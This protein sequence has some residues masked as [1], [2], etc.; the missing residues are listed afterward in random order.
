M[1]DTFEIRVNGERFTLWETSSVTRSIEANCGSFR[2]SSTQTV[3][4]NYPVREGDFIQI[5]INDD[6]KITG[7][8]DL[9]EASGTKDQGQGVTVSGRDNIQD[10]IDSSMPDAVKEMT[11]PISLVTLCQNV[12]DA[13]GANIPVADFSAPPPQASAL[14]DFNESTD[15]TSDSG[16]KCMDFLV[17][18]A[19]KKQVY[20]VP[21][22]NGQ[23]QLFRPGNERATTSLLNEINGVENN[24]TSW[25]LSKNRQERFY[26]YRIRSQ[27]NFSADDDADYS[28]A[29]IDRKGDAIDDEIRTTRYFEKQAPESFDDDENVQ[30]ATEMANLRRALAIS[31]T[32]TVQGVAQKNGVVW[33]FGQNVHV[34]DEYAGMRG[35]FTIKTVTYSSSVRGGSLTNITVVSPEAY[36]VRLPTKSD[37]RKAEEAPQYSTE[38][39]EATTLP[40]WWKTKTTVP[41]WFTR[42]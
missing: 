17:D 28:A 8:V 6:P 22:G 1:T 5:M 33:D 20:L 41:T 15:F 29:G 13:L 34:H 35:N 30:T 36:H 32:C 23:L 3:P 4:A 26:Q 37:K 31:Y 18:F 42:K 11:G 12:I 7:Y 25:K 16:R 39:T 38:E 21:D 40:K 10:V 9:I 2:F 24:I 19:R 27:D 14:T